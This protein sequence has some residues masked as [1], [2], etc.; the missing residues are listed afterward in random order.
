MHSI[1]EGVKTLHKSYGKETGGKGAKYAE[2]TRL[3]TGIFDLDLALGGGIPMGAV[4]I[5]YGTEGSGKTSL[6]IRCAVEFQK[7]YP[8]KK[9]AWL[10]V[11]NQWDEKWARLHGLDCDQLFMFKPTTSEE[12]SDQADQVAFSEDAGLLIIDSIAA[13]ATYDMLEKDAN[14]SIVG[15]AKT[16]TTMMRKIAG[17]MMEH[18]KAKSTLTVIYIN[19][20]RTKIGFVMGNPE[21]LPGPNYQNYQA[22]LKL[23]L[24]SKPI[25]KEKVAAIPIYSDNTARVAKKKFPAI[26]NAAAWQT[27]LYPHNGHKPLTLN[28]HKYMEKVLEDLGYL[29]K[30]DKVWLLY[31]EVF[32]TKTAAVQ[33]ALNDYDK[34]M[35][36]LVED[37]L[38]LYKDEL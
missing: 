38:L 36:M 26:R 32:P 27:I 4:S 28:N 14:T 34:T 7:R 11:E 35:T 12:A 22:F 8:N 16:S 18:A 1:H 24:T 9:I 3:P 31:G 6:A 37:L 13:L 21:F 15:S 5:F 10:D 17:G 23:R 2:F 33:S 25:M 20:V 29:E 30:A 19:Q